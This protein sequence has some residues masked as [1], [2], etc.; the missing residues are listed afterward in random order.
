MLLLMFFA[1]IAG[2]GAAPHPAPYAWSDQFGLRVQVAGAV[3]THLHPEVE[4]DTNA[5]LL[6]SYRDAR[7]QLA[8]VVGVGHGAYVARCRNELA[9]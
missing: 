2:A 3:G 1:L 9:A 5:T 8:G 4:D 6:V 7:G